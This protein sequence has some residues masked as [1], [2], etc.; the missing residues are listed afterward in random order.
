MRKLVWEWPPLEFD[1]SRLT[2][3]ERGNK[4]AIMILPSVSIL[5][6]WMKSKMTVNSRRVFEGYLKDFMM[7]PHSVPPKAWPTRQTIP[8]PHY[9]QRKRRVCRFRGDERLSIARSVQFLSPAALTA[10]PR[11]ERRDELYRAPL[12]LEL[13]S[14]LFI[15]NFVT[16]A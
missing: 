5:E 6:F 11:T 3:N 1:I 9:F 15:E 16:D 14:T 12:L 10:L 7:K 4:V 8:R 2:L 13:S